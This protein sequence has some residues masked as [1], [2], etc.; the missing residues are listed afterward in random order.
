MSLFGSIQL[1]GNTLQAMQI[2]LQVVGNNIANANT[3]GYVRQEAVYVP[4]G[5]QKHGNLILGMGVEVDSIIQKIDKFV[6]ERLVGARGE[7]ANAEVQEHVYRELETLLNELSDTGDL[8]SAL[9]GFFN[10]VEQLLTSDDV[11]TRNLAVGKGI[12]LASDFNKLQSRVVNLQRELDRRVTSMADEINNLTEQI[13]VLNIQIASAEGGDTSGS[14]AGGLRV[15]RQS[16][17]DRLSALLGIHVAEQTSGGLNISVGGELLVFEG[18]RREV[19]VNTELGAEAASGI[20]EFVGTNSPV[21]SS[22]GELNGLYTSRDD[23]I[24][25]F[26]EK[27]DDLAATL[28]FEFNKMYSQGQGLV[29]FEQLTSRDAVMN[30]N[31]ALDEAGLAFTPV[32]GS[33]ELI[34]SNKTDRNL[35]QTQVIHIDLSG[36]DEDT[37]LATLAEQLDAVDGISASVTS[38]GHLQIESDSTDSDFA[39]SGDTSGLLAALGLNTFFTGSTAATIG[40]N[41]E[42]KGI[43]NA[44][45]FATSLGGIGED[46]DNAARLA[47]FLDRPLAAAN[48]TSLSDLYN[49]LLNEITHGSAI[50]QSVADGF[51]TFEGSLEGQSQAVSG[52]S[53]DEEAVKMLTLQ[54]IFQASAKFIQTISDLLDLL[55][56]L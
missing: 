26:L 3:P 5:V 23:V 19:H 41:D 33:F 14:D 36:L 8:S 34:V 11:A 21:N 10:A 52:V 44:G 39:F 38:T 2:G 53:I 56:N 35:T 16:A 45:K 22:T 12:T 17:V 48:D 20:I 6:Q 51:R 4:A 46:S 25:G 47:V 7:R 13:R 42:V 30:V 1:G 9:T 40:V 54:R 24:G 31:A 29:G 15:Q 28:A 55:V 27:L 43:S 37:T 49:Q 32:S 18:Q 50:S